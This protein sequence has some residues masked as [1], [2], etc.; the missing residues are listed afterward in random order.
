MAI[1]MYIKGHT[2]IRSYSI[3]EARNQLPSLV[4]EVEQ[5]GPVSFTR[6]GHSV[7][8]LISAA[9]YERL[10]K[11]KVDFWAGLLEFRE[12]YDLQELDLDGALIDTRDLSPGRE[13]TW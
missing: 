13:H 12:K 1:L 8:V 6:R 4:H 2:M 5:G 9:E 10:S 3:A 7:A 11:P